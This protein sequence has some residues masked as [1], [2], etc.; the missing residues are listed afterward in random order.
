[1]PAD[2]ILRICAMV[3]ASISLALMRP[4]KARS[5]KK[6][7]PSRKRATLLSC[8]V[9]LGRRVGSRSGSPSVRT[10]WQP[11]LRFGA[12]AARHTAS[13]KARPPA[14][15]V[16]EVTIPWVCASMMARFTPVVKPKSSALTMSLRTRQS[17]RAVGDCADAGG[18]PRA[19]GLLD[20]W[21]D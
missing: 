9:M 1:M 7:S 16:E 21:R 10:T 20:D 14:I 13:S 15:R 19:Q 6:G 3:S 17:S 12:C 4:D 11:I 2:W 18:S 5:A 8:V